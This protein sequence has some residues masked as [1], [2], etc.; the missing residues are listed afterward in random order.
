MSDE[1]IFG[2]G[3]NIFE[4]ILAR[5]CWNAQLLFHPTSVCPDDL[6]LTSRNVCVSRCRV[7]PMFCKVKANHND[8]CLHAHTPTERSPEPND[9]EV[10]LSDNAPPAEGQ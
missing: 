1:N 2:E 4:F 8:S 5:D 9:A 3:G 6:C 10:S 7:G